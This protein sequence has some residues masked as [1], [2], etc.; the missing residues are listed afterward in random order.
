MKKYLGQKDAMKEILDAYEVEDF[1]EVAKLVKQA[2][3]DDGNGGEGEGN[4]P[5]Q[6]NIEDNEE[7][8]KLKKANA[9]ADAKMAKT[10]STVVAQ[11]ATLKNFALQPNVVANVQK[12]LCSPSATLQC[13]WLAANSLQTSLHAQAMK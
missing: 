3:Q 13:V 10:L 7:Y 11:Q 9:D 12:C 6:V 4:K 2:L 5:A 1:G 8:K